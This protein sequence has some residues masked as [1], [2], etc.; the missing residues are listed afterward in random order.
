MRYLLKHIKRKIKQIFCKHSYKQRSKFYGHNKTYD[1]DVI[2]NYD[3][4]CIKCGKVTTINM[5]ECEQLK[6]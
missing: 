1:K 2:F 6:N 4:E 5:N 3:F